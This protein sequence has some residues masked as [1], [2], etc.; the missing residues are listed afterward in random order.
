[1][2]MMNS[3]TTTTTTTT[4]PFKPRPFKP[5]DLVRSYSTYTTAQLEYAAPQSENI[6][7]TTHQDEVGMVVKAF[8]VPGLA[9]YEWYYKVLFRDKV[10]ICGPHSIKPYSSSCELDDDEICEEKAQK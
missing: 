3:T 8:H 1:M 5:G 10:V 9:L 4:R 7:F 2:T 6:L